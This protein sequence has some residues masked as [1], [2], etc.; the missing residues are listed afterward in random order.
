MASVLSLQNAHPQN[1]PR[2]I[3]IILHVVPL[4]KEIPNRKES[5][6]PAVQMEVQLAA[7]HR[8]RICAFNQEA[9]VMGLAS[10]SAHL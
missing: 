3:A 1:G 2:N 6:L 5:T 10:S 8:I 4:V 7:V 9:S